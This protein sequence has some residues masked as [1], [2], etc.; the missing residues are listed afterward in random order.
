MWVQCMNLKKI[1]KLFTSE[2]VG[3]RPS[4]Y[5]GEKKK[6][7]PGRGLTKVEK[8]CISVFT[9][10]RCCASRNITY[11]F[12]FRTHSALTI[13]WLIHVSLMITRVECLT[14][15]YYDYYYYYWA[16]HF[17]LQASPTWPYQGFFFINWWSFKV[18]AALTMHRFP[19]EFFYLLVFSAG[20][21]TRY[22]G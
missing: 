20:F 10:C 19:L 7:L 15:A 14:L 8:H 2:Y 17:S 12:C 11:A 16:L 6:N 3:I 5:G 21:D 9:R 18:P 22:F 1:G 13:S 4:S